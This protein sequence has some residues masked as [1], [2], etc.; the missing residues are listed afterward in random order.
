MEDLEIAASQVI[1]AGGYGYISSGAGDLFTYQ[2]NERAFNH[3]LIIPHVLR[4]VELPDTTTHFDEEMLT[5][6]IIM[7]PVAAHG[8]AHV[9]AEKASAK[10]VA[11]FGTI[12]TASS[13]ALYFRRDK[14]SRRGE[15]TAMVSI[16]YEQR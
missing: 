2:E 6:P 12:Y 8:L 7:A 10:G 9:K 11:D 1:P 16:L 5:A 3:R 13:Y 14:R 4:D 15:S